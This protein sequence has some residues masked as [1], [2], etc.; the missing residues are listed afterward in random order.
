MKKV[1]SNLAWV[2]VFIIS[3]GGLFEP[4]LGLLLL[5]MIVFMFFSGMLNGKYWCGNL[6]P[7]GILFD[8]IIEMISRNKHIPRLL[9]NKSVV[10]F[11]LIAFMSGMAYRVMKLISLWGEA[12]LL[13]K[14]GVVMVGNYTLVTILGIA[15]AIAYKPRAWCRVCPMGSFQMIVSK[16]FFL[17]KY[18][19]FLD[20]K[21]QLIEGKSCVGCKKCTKACPIEIE[22]HKYISRDS[23]VT[24]DLCIKCGKCVEAC[25]LKV[26]EM[27]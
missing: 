9:K 10:A 14:L 8:R 26:I 7:H 23:K 22:P 12:D 21:V 6:C 19:P 24:T 18:V 17:K 13:E 27:S 1:Y 15:L 3:L 11:G 25:P 16:A 2:I 5:P 20:A 4:R